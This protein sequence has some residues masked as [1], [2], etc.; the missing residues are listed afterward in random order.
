MQLGEP[1]AE[2]ERLVFAQEQ[3]GAVGGVVLVVAARDDGV[4]PVIAAAL[5][6]EQ[7]LLVAGMA[8]RE[9]VLRQAKRTQH[10][11]AKRSARQAAGLEEVASLHVHGA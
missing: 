9:E 4:D 2:V 8:I 10:V 1:V 6:D 3:G 5:E 7:H 11:Q